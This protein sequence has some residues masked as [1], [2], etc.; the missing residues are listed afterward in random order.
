MH[1][2]VETSDGERTPMN[3]NFDLGLA[4]G[5]VGEDARLGIKLKVQWVWMLVIA[6]FVGLNAHMTFA[7]GAESEAAPATLTR[8]A[9][10]GGP[11]AI[12]KPEEH[13][14]SQKAV[15]VTRGFGFS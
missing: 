5:S 9:E 2:R 14:L 8:T 4:R 11:E 3:N 13:G 12:S 15:E 1:T 10:Q 6:V 7:A